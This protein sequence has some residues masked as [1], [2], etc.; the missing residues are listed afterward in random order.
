MKKHDA[1]ATYQFACSI[2]GKKF[3]KK[4]CVVAHKAKSHPEVLIAEALAANAGSLIMTPVSM[5]ELQGN[6]IQ[7]EV[8]GLDVSQLAQGGQVNQL[9]HEGQ[10]AQLGHVTQQVSHQVV[11]LGRYQS[12]HTMQMPVTIALCPPSLADHQQTHLQHAGCSTAPNP[13]A[14]PPLQPGGDPASTPA[15]PSA[16]VLL[17]AAGADTNPSID[18]SAGQ[19]VSDPHSLDLS[20]APDPPNSYN[21]L[22]S[23]VLIPDLHEW[24]QLHS[25]RCSALVLPSVGQL[26][27]ADG[28]NGGGQRGLGAGGTE[29][30]S[31]GQRREASAAAAPHVKDKT[32]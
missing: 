25:G 7:A 8:A 22:P 23:P 28:S 29:G 15:A 32:T 1:D 27:C 10:V 12:L 20:A 31:V 19:P 4:D 24:A 17:P 16:V 2:C 11:V 14:D 26:P 5:L 21:E 9:S 6:P 30:G 18:L 3:E 13:T